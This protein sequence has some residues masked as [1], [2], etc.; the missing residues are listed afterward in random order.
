MDKTISQ[1]A[2]LKLQLYFAA[3]HLFGKGWSYPQVF[4]RLKEFA[5]TNEELLKNVLDKAL[6]DEWEKLSQEVHLLLSKG[7][8][9]DIVRKEILLKEE[10]PEIADFICESWYNLKIAYAD[11]VIEGNTNLAEGLQWVIIS[12]VL[13]IAAFLLDAK[14]V[15]RIISI[16]LFVVSGLLWMVGRRMKRNAE[17]IERFFAVSPD[18]IKS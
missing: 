14:T 4:E 8:S 17:S 13:I 3:Q 18:N 5:G 10:D 1:D 15:F 2:N 12:L 9:Y 6:N 7:V 16:V 11:S